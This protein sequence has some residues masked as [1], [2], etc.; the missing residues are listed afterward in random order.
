MLEEVFDVITPEQFNENRVERGK[1]VEAIIYSPL[2]GEQITSEFLALIPNLRTFCCKSTGTDTLDFDV[3]RQRGVTWSNLPDVQ[4]ETCADMVF[5]LI[6]SISRRIIEGS[7]R[8]KRPDMKKTS[9]TFLG[10]DVSGTTLGIV[11]MG[12]I[13][14]IVAEKSKAFRMKVLYNSRR[15]RPDEDEAKLG[16]VYY[17]KLRE[18]LPLVDFLVISCA[19]T[20]ETEGA[21]G[22][23]EFELMK[24]SSTL[25][26]IAR[27][28][29]VDTDALVTALQTGAIR[30]AALDVTNP[31]PLPKDHPLLNM[32]NVLVT[33]HIASS[34][35]GTRDKMVELCIENVIAGLEGRIFPDGLRIC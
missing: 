27:G 13:G 2:V 19:L 10:Q 1:E 5:A 21:I 26:N 31:E 35:R 3:F 23:R 16:A 7:I 12:S 18:M 32:D 22:A 20:P 33:P 11:G 9:Y 28:A 8:A 29:I 17:P 14:C 6:L 34:T 24:P 30:A 4:S 25:I 15:K